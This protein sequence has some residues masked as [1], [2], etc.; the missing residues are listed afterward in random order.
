MAVADYK[1]IFL[2]ISGVLYSG[3]DAIAGAAEA[4]GTLRQ[5]GLQLRFLTNTSRRRA[6]DIVSVLAGLGIDTAPGEVIT[7]PLFPLRC[8]TAILYHPGRP[9][10]FP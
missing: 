1:A 9:V 5:A 6:A 3:D 8:A 10:A 2:D 7:A 4:V